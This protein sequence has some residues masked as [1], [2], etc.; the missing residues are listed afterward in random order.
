MIIL[1][2]SEAR[3]GSTNLG[4]WLRKSLPDYVVLNE[5][6]NKRS[7]DYVNKEH[8][9][10][11]WINPNKNYVINE[12]FY[13][14][15]GDLNK[16]ILFSDVTVCLYR[17]DEVKQIESFVISAVTDKWYGEYSDT[18]ITSKID[19]KY[20]HLRDYFKKLK[21]DFQIFIKENGL[22]SF[23]YEDLYYKNKIEDFK[24]YIG[25]ESNIKFPYGLKYRKEILKQRTII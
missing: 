9:D 24:E 5:P 4:F 25:I 13:P 22:K 6:Y 2:L 12:K 1:V 18:S 19:E 8:Y 20:S 14:G 3:S 11:S 16:L 15:C 7:G 17:E 23:T 21:N 10:I